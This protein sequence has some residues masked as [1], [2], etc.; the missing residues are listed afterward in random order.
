MNTK[1]WGPPLWKALDAKAFN[2]PV[3]INP[4]SK[5]HQALKKRYK[6]EF[7]LQQYTLPCK[8]CRKS[9]TKF[10]REL[11]I[12]DFLSSRKDLTYWLYLIHDKVNQKLL[13]QE[14]KALEERY[15]DIKKKKELTQAQKNRLRAKARREILYTKPSPS[16]ESYCKRMEQHRAKCAKKRGHIPSCRLPAKTKRKGKPKTRSKP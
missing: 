6:Q 1:F 10:L 7:E 9:Y 4:R 13:L 8:Y 12:D 14:K 3:K 2:Y 11:P 5:K 16:Y 15:A